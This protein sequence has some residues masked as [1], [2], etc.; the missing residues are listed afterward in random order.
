MSSI[1][2]RS[3]TASARAAPAGAHSAASR[4]RLVRLVEQLLDS[5]RAQSRRAA[6]A[7]RASRS[8]GAVPRV[9]DVTCPTRRR[10]RASSKPTGRSSGAGIRVRL[11]QVMTN[12]VSNALRYSPRDAS[13]AGPRAARGARA[14]AL[15]RA[16]AASAFPRRSSDQLFTP[17]FRGA[18][19]RVTPRAAGSGSACTSRT[20]SCGATAA[21]SASTRARAHGTTFTVELPRGLAIS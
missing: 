14:R 19:A 2:A 18:N 1:P 17:F 15:G 11:E 9:L 7:A 6:A 4:Q 3:P 12:L 10:A 13:R 16:T 8:G 5:A 20:R 21:P